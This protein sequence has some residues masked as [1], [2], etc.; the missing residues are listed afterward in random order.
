MRLYELEILSI[1][2]R[3]NLHTPP[4]KKLD[5]DPLDAQYNNRALVPDFG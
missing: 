2:D 1:K 4:M 5:S 3:S